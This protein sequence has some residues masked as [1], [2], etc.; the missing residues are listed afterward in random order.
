MNAI[1]QISIIKVLFFYLT[2]FNGTYG[3]FSDSYLFYNRQTKQSISLVLLNNRINQEYIKR[4]LENSFIPHMQSETPNM[5]WHFF[6]ERQDQTFYQD[7]QEL[8]GTCVE[9]SFPPNALHHYELMMASES[10]R[11]ILEEWLTY[12]CLVYDEAEHFFLLRTNEQEK[13][14][15]FHLSSPLK[16]TLL[17]ILN[18]SF[19]QKRKYFF[20]LLFYQENDA[21]P[22]VHQKE[23]QADLSKALSPLNFSYPFHVRTC[24]DDL[25]T[26]PPSKKE[27]EQKSNQIRRCSNSL[28]SAQEKAKKEF[29]CTLCKT[30]SYCS[31]A[32]KRAH[33]KHEHR[34]KHPLNNKFLFQNAVIYLDHGAL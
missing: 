16:N 14:T 24:I 15:T 20:L 11:D 10:A 28:C 6:I 12:R 7:I 17:S 22:L 4:L 29:T 9:K 19:M 13:S 33:W 2:L 30:V 18:Y 1:K 8:I 32:C 3:S 34:K 5:Y 21:S 25:I 27:K 23:F 31:L 26:S